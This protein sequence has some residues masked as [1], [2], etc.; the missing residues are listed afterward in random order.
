[1]ICVTNSKDVRKPLTFPKRKSLQ[2]KL[3]L[4]ELITFGYLIIYA[5][6]RR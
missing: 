1:M 6:V 2:P 5:N 4:I 3:I